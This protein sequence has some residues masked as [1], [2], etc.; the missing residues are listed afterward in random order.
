MRCGFH[1]TY[2]KKGT[3]VSKWDEDILSAMKESLAVNSMRIV[4]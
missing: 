2:H 1:D 4:L 3:F